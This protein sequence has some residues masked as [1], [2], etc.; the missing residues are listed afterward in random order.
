LHLSLLP[1][2]LAALPPTPLASPT[3]F[4]MPLHP[5]GDAP[6]QFFQRQVG[7]SA[8]GGDGSL[9]RL[10]FGRFCRGFG[11]WQLVGI[12]SWCLEEPSGP[13]LPA[14]ALGNIVLAFDSAKFGITRGA[15][16]TN[17]SVP[18][19]YY[20]RKR[21]LAVTFGARVRSKTASW[22][23]AGLM[24]PHFAKDAIPRILLSETSEFL[25]RTWTWRPR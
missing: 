25:A 23:T 12:F 19:V 10:R 8:R 1:R 5:A 21:E 3:Q 15:V 9:I 20:L 22:P 24:R 4:G 14:L 6:C 17:V 11:A 18:L 2:S 13:L 16:I 7:V